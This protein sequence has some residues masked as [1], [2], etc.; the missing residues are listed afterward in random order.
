[1]T[2]FDSDPSFGGPSFEELNLYNEL[3]LHSGELAEALQSH[4]PI[5]IDRSYRVSDPLLMQQLTI[6][7]TISQLGQVLPD[8]QPVEVSIHCTIHASGGL[9][10]G[11]TRI[12]LN[13]SGEK[14]FIRS[15]DDAH[16]LVADTPTESEDGEPYVVIDPRITS[17]LIAKL[18]IPF[19]E[20]ELCDF[21]EI[22][23]IA[24]I[25]EICASLESS[26]FVDGSIENTY[27]LPGNFTVITE[28][29]KESLIGHQIPISIEVT[30]DRGDDT[31]PL[32]LSTEF[33]DYRS[34]LGML[35]VLESGS[36]EVTLDVDHMR[37][38][39]GVVV[40][41]LKIVQPD[42]VS[43]EDYDEDGEYIN[44]YGD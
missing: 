4:E 24:R 6:T 9:Q 1:M 33:T 5:S 13:Y 11:Q 3:I 29:K 16:Y 15:D 25:N 41:L 2:I 22:N 35:R 38:F 32:T 39:K 43:L 30:E 44:P 20:P 37:H 19:T 14:F 42:S 18:T 23:S 31:D 8:E 34:A 28:T 7:D 17:D 12:H 27:K 10:Y 36:E 21:T 40:N 26:D